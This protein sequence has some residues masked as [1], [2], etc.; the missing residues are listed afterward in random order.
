[1]ALNFKGV[2]FT[3]QKAL[4]LMRDGGA[5]VINASWTLHR[6]MTTGAVYAATKAAAHNLARTFAT[7]LA[8]RGIRVNSISPGF[9]NTGQFNEKTVGADKARRYTAQ[10]PLGRFGEADKV[11][12]VVAFLVS[13]QASY[14]T[15]H[16]VI[17]GGMVPAFQA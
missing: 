11:A 10:V 2:F 15:G 6:A 14:L 7:S 1:V 8:P 3:V 5:I 13:P 17:D 4:P 12:A 9:I 16:I